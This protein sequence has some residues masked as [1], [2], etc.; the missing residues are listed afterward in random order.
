MPLN[1]FYFLFVDFF[2]F[3]QKAKVDIAG[4]SL[5]ENTKVHLVVT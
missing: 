3:K 5:S 4:V 1:N 2:F